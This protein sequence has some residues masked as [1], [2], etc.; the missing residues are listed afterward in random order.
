MSEE[1][2][3]ITKNGLKYG[4][5]GIGFIIIPLLIN[6]LIESIGIQLYNITSFFRP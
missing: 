3:D 4:L 2:D 6:W 1:E 5:L